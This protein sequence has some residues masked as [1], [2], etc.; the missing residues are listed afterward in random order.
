MPKS[1]DRPLSGIYAVE[2]PENLTS[3]DLWKFV[4]S[5]NDEPFAIGDAK[6]DNRF[7][8]S[9]RDTWGVSHVMCLKGP[10]VPTEI[11]DPL[12]EAFRED[13]CQVSSFLIAMW[14]Y[15][16]HARV[17]YAFGG[18]D[19]EELTAKMK[20][21]PFGAAKLKEKSLGHHIDL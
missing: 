13:G 19:L 12:L 2:P 4:K 9:Q 21:S 3:A 10:G 14:P 17:M 7:T 8:F 6:I 15:I 16:Q 5:L 20:A 18:T 11:K 1:S